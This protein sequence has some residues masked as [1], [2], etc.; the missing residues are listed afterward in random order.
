MAGKRSGSILNNNAMVSEPRERRHT[1]FSYIVFSLFVT[2]LGI[3]VLIGG[4]LLYGQR[5]LEAT[6][7][8]TTATTAVVKSG[9]GS[10]EIA[11]SL[12]SQGIISNERIFHVASAIYHRLGRTLKAGEYSFEPGDSMQA[13]FDKI[14]KGKGV[15]HKITVP[16]GW[17]SMQALHRI[18]EHPVLTGDMPDELDEGI[19]LPDT[20]AFQRGDTRKQVIDRMRAA[21]VKLMADLWANRAPEL[22]LKS[23]EEALILASIVEK[24]TGVASE[25]KRV[26]SVF[27]NRLNRN[28]RLQS[29]PT[30]I[31]GIVGGKGKLGRPIRRSE[32]DAKTPYNTYQIDGL[33]PTPIAN[34]GKAAIEAVLQP[35]NTQDLYFV[36]DGSGGHVFASTLAEHL[37]NVKNYRKIERAERAAAALAAKQSAAE[38]PEP[39]KTT[40]AAASEAK[41]ESEP[42][43]TAP[44]ATDKPADTGG[45]ELPLKAAD[46]PASTGEAAG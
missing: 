20:Y 4:T 15:S 24:E 8:L 30:I 7:P 21:Q 9:Q 2:L 42:A 12:A 29:D 19:L 1:S 39:A 5:Q 36:A 41:T 31:Y 35:A 14:S 27:I 46:K 44:A 28:M 17:T 45:D 16:E 32:I 22:P 34:P 38:T 6:G 43:A 26:A 37:V 10:A 13:V 40:P 18:R 11:A 25:R 3:A 23:V 33:P